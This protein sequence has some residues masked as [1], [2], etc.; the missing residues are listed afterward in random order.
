MA[1][2]RSFKNNRGILETDE[3]LNLAAADQ[4]KYNLRALS[5]SHTQPI[6]KKATPFDRVIFYNGMHGA[7]GENCLK[8][9]IGAKVKM[10]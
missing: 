4:S 6:K 2:E 3:Y 9:S 1:L 8:V 7:V 5:V 10:P